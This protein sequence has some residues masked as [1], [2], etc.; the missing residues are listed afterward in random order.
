LVDENGHDISFQ[1][2]IRQGQKKRIQFG[3][4]DIRFGKQNDLC[5]INR[6]VN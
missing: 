6:A 3:T 1:H 2:E 4:K 5:G